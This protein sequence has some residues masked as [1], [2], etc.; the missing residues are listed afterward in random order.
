M[1]EQTPARTT[2][3]GKK[4]PETDPEENGRVTKRVVMRRERVLMLPENFDEAA[5]KTKEAMKLLGVKGV[6]EAWM[7]VGE[8]EGSSK[9]QA[10]VAHAGK[11]NTPEAIP[12]TYKAPSVTAWAGGRRYVK[13]PLP[14]V[15]AEDID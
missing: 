14:K 2:R 7:V 11:P 13:P 10:I 9:N 12:G 1:A 5:D 3:A 8:F 15:E 6:D 4:A